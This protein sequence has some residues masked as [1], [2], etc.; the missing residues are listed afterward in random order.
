MRYMPLADRDAALRTRLRELAE[1]R[2]RFGYRR[3]Y[4][5]L[6]REGVRVN[7]KRIERLYRQERLSLRGR[8]RK[9]LRCAVRVVLGVASRPNEHWSMDF[10][11]DQTIDGRRFRALTI[12]DHCSREAPPIA[13][14]RSFSGRMV[15]QWLEQLGQTRGAWPQLIS[16]DNGSEFV[17][18]DFDAW[19]YSRGIKLHFI[20]PGK[21]VQNC[22]IESFN[23]RL[24]DE[25]LNEHVFADLDEAEQVIERWRQD[26]NSCRPHGSLGKRTPEEFLKSFESTK[27]G[28]ITTPEVVR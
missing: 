25:C 17:S 21:P 6:R 1:Q 3:L 4:W 28:Q 15:A 22:F 16:L 14:R 26:Y 24:R 19:A 2:R 10:V 23:G 11:H 13:V 20:E 18:R 5:L 27:Q 8:H 9:R 7:H 12:L